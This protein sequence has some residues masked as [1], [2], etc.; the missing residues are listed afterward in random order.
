MA[1]PLA[2]RGIILMNRRMTMDQIKKS[3]RGKWRL[4][5]L[6]LCLAITLSIAGAMVYLVLTNV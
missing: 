6:Q 1:L 3:S 5:L 4:N 2:T